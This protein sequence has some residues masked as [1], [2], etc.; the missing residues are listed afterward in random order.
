MSSY[1]KFTF[2]GVLTEE[3]IDFFNVHGFIH[4]EHYASEETVQAII[5]STE[6]VQE[7]WIAND[8]QK[9]NGIPIKIWKGRNRKKDRSLLCIH[10]PVQQSG[11]RLHFSSRPRGAKSSDASRNTGR[12]ERKR[13]RGL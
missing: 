12:P 11:T 3:Q 9:V 10:Q 1:Q 6:N 4:F 2:D 5:A 8:V 7:Q 13:W